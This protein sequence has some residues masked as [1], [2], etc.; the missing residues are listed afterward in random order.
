MPSAYGNRKRLTRSIHRQY[1]APFPD[2]GS[3]ELVLFALAQ[4]LLG[5]TGY[6]ENL[7]ERRETLHALPLTVLWGVKDSAFPPKVLQRW[8]DTFPH[9]R[10]HTFAGAG[11]WP[12]EEEPEA[13][14]AAL[15]G[16]LTA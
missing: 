2:A 4:S 16:A 15:R 3:R 12:H 7:W 5:S 13:F 11:H 9:A 6:Y 8:Q 10:V 1:L 14:V